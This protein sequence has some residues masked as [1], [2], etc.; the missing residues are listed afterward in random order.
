MTI[1]TASRNGTFPHDARHAAELYLQRGM[2]PIPLPPRSKDPGYAGLPQ[3][4]LTPDTLDAHFPAGQAR[5]V[6]ILNGSPSRDQHDVDL[7]SVEA[8]RAAPLLLPATGLVFGRAS[9]P[10]SHWIYRADRSLDTAQEEYKDIDGTMVVE[11]RGSGGLTVFPPSAHRETGETIC[12][13]QF[14]EPGSV[15]LADLQRAVRHVAAAALLARRWPAKGSRDEAAL[16]MTG[17]LLRDGWSQED[18]SRFVEA[19]AVAAG[20]EEAKARSKKAV[21]TSAKQEAGKKTTGWPTLAKTLGPFG[22]EVI[23]RVREWLGIAPSAGTGAAKANRPR[24]FTPYKPFPVDM[25]PAPLAAFVAQAALGCDPAFV[26]LPILAVV[27][28]TIGNTRSIRLK[29]DWTEPCIVWS[30][31]VADSGTLKSPAMRKGVAFLYR[32]QKL[33]RDQVKADMEEYEM[34]LAAYEA[35]KK[36]AEKKGEDPPGSKPE[37]PVQKRVVCSDTTIEKLAEIL[38]DNPRSFLTCRDEL[39]AWLGSF[40]RYKGRQGG[41]DL[42]NWLEMWQ[43]GT[44]I[45]DRKTGDRTSLFISPASV[46]VTGGIQPGVLGANLTQEFIHAGLPARI[47]MAMPVKKPKRW[48]DA[49]VDHEVEQAYHDVLD[50]LLTLEFDTRDAE[51]QPYSLPLSPE[52]KAV[53][54]EFYNGWAQEQAGVDG[55]LAAA[56]AKLEAYAARFALLH[57]VVNRVARGEDDRAPV[58]RESVEAG[59]ALCRWFANEARR[60]YSMLTES[61]EERETRRLVEWVRTRGGRVTAKQ[62]QQA[63][64]KYRT[65]DAAAL[66]LD[67]LAQAG[68]GEWE[69]RPPGA[70]GGRPTKVFV[71]HTSADETDETSPGD[72]D[73]D[74]G[75]PTEPADETP[76]PSDTTPSKHGDFEVSSVSSVVGTGSPESGGAGSKTLAGGRVSSALPRGVSSAPVPYQLVTDTASLATVL[77]ALAEPTLIGLDLETTGLDSRTDRVRLLSLAV[78][79]VD[80]STYA[81]LID[82]FALDPAPLWERLA[83]KDLI[84][85]NAHFDL[86]FL[87]KLGFAPAGKVYDTMLVAQLLVAGRNERA[88][89]AACCERWLGRSLDKAEQMS[90]WSGELT[91]D[92]LAYAARDVQVLG[93]LLKMLGAKLKEVGVI[94]AAKI[95]QRCLPAV[96]WMGQHGVRL[97]RQ[98]WL[99]LARS[100]DEEAER[101]REELNEAAPSRPESALFP[102]PWNW[103]STQQAKEALGLAGCS[104]DDTSDETLAWVDHPLAQ[105]LR[106]YRLARKRGGTYGTDW[107]ARVA[108]DGRVYPSGRQ[109]GAA[110]GRMSCSDPNMQQLPRGDYR[111]CVAAP[112]GRVLVKADYS[113]IELRIAAKISGDAALLDAYHRGEDLHARTARN[114]LGIEDVTK[115]HRQLAKALNFGLLYGMGARGFRLYAK[116]QYG[117]DLSEDEARRYRDAFFQTYPGLA[118]WHRHVRSRRAMETRTL[119]GR[120]RLL[121]DKTPDTHRLNTPVQGT[122]ADGLKL[123]LGLL[124]E[125]RDQVPG[126]FPVLAVHDEIVVECDAAQGETVATWLKAAM[127]EAM[128]PLIDPIPVQVEVRIG[129]TWGG[130]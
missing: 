10:G 67:A 45:V 51:A 122:G 96:V 15:Q 106:R 119:A 9:S 101:V 44:A 102:E 62:L 93:P 87:A 29:R 61:R 59:I 109:L 30:A 57:H 91:G 73:D 123:A 130:E 111:R 18:V 5:N 125:R 54:V 47:L 68:Y 23:D 35:A 28:S 43:A 94:D 120:R 84:I 6:G 48:S 50:K 16:A 55:E 49:E 98:R 124:W 3:L 110:S 25:L 24:S 103:D 105:L 7:D 13:E 26:A 97:D 38:E 75:Q 88:T 77:T 20:D 21:P 72:E 99:E 22:A 4:R 40:A 117:L 121:N 27:A 53:W 32:R 79:T 90:D 116:S 33:L 118:A 86:A 92:Q 42:P 2:A 52:A 31:I 58:E 74:G 11:L 71:L 127:V 83:A 70:R 104:V 115:Q 81:Y 36:K 69:D 39:S 65:A 78:P 1:G 46:S 129:T 128:A 56:F 82:C 8:R 107:L 89:L 76:P 60:I 19:V 41:S 85:H 66:A 63:T 37:R 17:G 64:S 100:A 126:A 108:N 114:V 80:G 112:P 14:S 34:K 95:E 12:W 113:Q